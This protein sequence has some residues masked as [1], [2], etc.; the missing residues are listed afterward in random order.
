MKLKLIIMPYKDKEKEREYQKAYRQN[1]ENKEK[2]KES[3]KKYANKPE[4]KEKKKEYLKEYQQT[5]SYKKSYRIY[6]WKQMK[7]ICADWNALYE[8]YLNTDKC[9]RCDVEL[10]EGT[11]RTNHKHLDHNHET[12]EVRNILCGYCNS[13]VLSHIRVYISKNPCYF[14]ECGCQ[15]SLKQKKDIDEH[16][17][18]NRHIELMKIKK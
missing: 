7:I 13:N 4:K 12:G 8:R 15:L 1:P 18:S 2:I 16:K 10:I 5:E 14:C 17:K 6:A 3:K 11:G 9:E